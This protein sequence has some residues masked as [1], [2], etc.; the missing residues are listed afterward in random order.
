[1]VP[2]PL[3]PIPGTQSG[4]LGIFIC[5]L[6]KAPISPLI[7]P[8]IPFTGALI[9]VTIESHILLVVFFTLFHMLVILSLI[10]LKAVPM[11]FLKPSIKPVTT[12]T[13]LFQTVLVTVLIP[14]HMLVM[15]FFIQ[16][17]DV[18]TTFLIPSII[19]V[20]T[21]LMPFQIVLV[22]FFMPF[23]TLLIMF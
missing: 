2:P 18:L 4:T 8:I 13:I 15:V 21:L 7:I 3:P 12:F 6:F 9:M 23:Q 22:I 20:I 5:T 17:K 19:P 10:Q 1:M 14:F 11:T 16:L